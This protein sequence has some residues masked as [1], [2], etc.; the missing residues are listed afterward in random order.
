MICR[1]DQL[2]CCNPPFTLT[3]VALYAKY[4]PGGLLGFLN[5]SNFYSLEAAY[6]VCSSDSNL[7]Q[8]TVFILGRMGNSRQALDL[9]ITE[10]KDVKQVLLALS[11]TRCLTFTNR[12]LNSLKTRGTKS[13]GRL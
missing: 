4:A 13:S 10:L 5:K 6:A 7:L 3:K 2:K 9:I 12:L 11:V 1:W 8:Q